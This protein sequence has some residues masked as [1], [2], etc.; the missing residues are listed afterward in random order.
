MCVFGSQVKLVQSVAVR[1][2]STSS[3][4]SSDLEITECPTE[5]RHP[6]PDWNDLVF[7]ANFSDHMFEVN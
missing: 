5:K 6:K 7:G 3:F 4:R 2:S 1:S